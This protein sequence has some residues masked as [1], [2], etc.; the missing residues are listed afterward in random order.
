[1]VVVPLSFH[2]RKKNTMFLCVW[3]KNKRSVCLHSA[4]IFQKNFSLFYSYSAFDHFKSIFR[5]SS[6]FNFET[7]VCSYVFIRWNFCTVKNK[8]KSPQKDRRRWKK[9]KNKRDS[10][11]NM[12][13]KPFFA[14]SNR[15]QWTELNAYNVHY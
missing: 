13:T 11:R 1:M 8:K 3:T 7:N 12:P 2:V 9:W 10:G 5:L 14:S 4:S 15:E 6:E